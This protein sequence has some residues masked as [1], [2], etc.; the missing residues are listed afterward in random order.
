MANIKG[1]AIKYTVIKNEDIKNL[2]G[3]S[4]RKQFREFCRKIE[5]HNRA[6]KDMEALDKNDY[7]TYLKRQDN[8]YLVINSDEPYADQIIDIMKANGHWGE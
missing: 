6:K 4:E 2:L 3:E 5:C 8:I 1:I 7:A